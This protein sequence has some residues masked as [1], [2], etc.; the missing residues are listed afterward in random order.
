MEREE[1]FTVTFCSDNRTGETGLAVFKEMKDGK[2]LTTKVE[3]GKQAHNLYFLLT[4]QS[5]KVEDIRV[6]KSESKKMIMRVEDTNMNKSMWE[7]LKN[8]K[9]GGK[10]DD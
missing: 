5:A 7:R 8:L 10:Q 3:T 4:N 9:N 1:V 6:N 2:S